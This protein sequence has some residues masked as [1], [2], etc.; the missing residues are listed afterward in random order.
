M[1][2]IELTP[3]YEVTEFDCG[4]EQLNK[5]LFEDAK[6]SLA[7]RVANTFILVDD[8]RVAAYFCLL[9][10][11]VSKDE[12]I[13]SRWKKV[14]ANFP[15]SKQFRSYPTIKI[16]RFAVSI[17]YRGKNIGTDLMDSIK[18]MLHAEHGRSA[19]RFITVDAYAAAI[20]FY[21]RNGFVPL[22]EED[23]DEPTRLLYFDLNDLDE[24]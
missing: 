4:D 20:P 24:D 7:L 13:G 3:D 11:K 23:A 2:L 1:D 21:L 22:N 19:F 16:G 6:P 9:N 18:A 15:Q 10:D 17:N 14:R 8:G 5:F 12:I